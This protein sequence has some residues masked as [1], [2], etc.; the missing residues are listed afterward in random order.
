MVAL[1]LLSI[2]PSVGGCTGACQGPGC[3]D[4]YPAARLSR[5]DPIGGAGSAAWPEE[6]SL[7]SDATGTWIGSASEGDDQVE[8]GTDWSASFV[9]PDVLIGQPDAERVVRVSPITGEG[10]VEPIAQWQSVASD[11]GT[12]VFVHRREPVLDL[13][14]GAPRAGDRLGPASDTA[15]SRGA[16]YVFRDVLDPPAAGAETI[17][18]QEAPLLVLGA[19]AADRIGTHITACSDLTGD[20]VAEILVGAPWFTTPTTASWPLD[21]EQDIPA[22]AGAVFLLESERVATASGVVF[23]WELG[24]VWW[25]ESSGDGLGQALACDTDLYLGA[26][27][28]DGTRGRVYRLSGD[29]L[30][31]SGPIPAEAALFDGPEP[32]AWFGASLTVLDFG[33]A[34]GLAVGSPGFGG[35]AGK[36]YAYEVDKGGDPRNIATFVQADAEQLDHLARS[37]TAADIDGDGID[38]LVVG[39]PDHRVAES[40][41]DV[42]RVWVWPGADRA[43]WG[44]D[45]NIFDA[46]HQVSGSH[47]FMRVG[48]NLAVG[49]PDGTGFDVLLVP[50]RA[51]AVQ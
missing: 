34:R 17:E 4:S 10:S 46:P 15:P 39:S 19:S 21:D 20:G 18:A 45:T 24:R 32:D 49:D 11:F 42:G 2:P 13:W 9:G 26:P 51:A 6:I 50:T 27:F 12:T 44:I 3:E 43:S 7:P 25:G 38:D 31:D 29:D 22:L 37:I 35:G 23:P 41:F 8:E 33:D 16:F 5:L 14:V 47:P 30:P 48:R 36:A 40:G 1:A 28:H